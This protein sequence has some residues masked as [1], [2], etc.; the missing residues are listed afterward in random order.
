MS[1]PERK[2]VFVD[3]NF[4]HPDT[5]LRYFLQS[6]EFADAT[7]RELSPTG[8]KSAPR[9]VK[10]ARLVTMLQSGEITPET[11]L[12]A[13][14]QQPR[15]WLAVW[16]VEGVTC[17]DLN[18]P[19]QFLSTGGGDQWFGPVRTGEACWYV[20]TK[21]VRHRDLDTSVPGGRWCKIRWNLIAEVTTQY[22]ALHWNGFTHIEDVKRTTD[23][24]FEFWR[25]IPAAVA[26][27]KDELG[28]TWKR[29]DL[30]SIV[31]DK[32]MEEFLESADPEWTHLRV[33]AELKGVAVNARSAGVRE[34]NVDGLEA[35]A[36]RL[37]ERAITAS[38]RTATAATVSAA[39]KAVLKTLL[40]EWGTRSYAFRLKGKERAE[41][42]FEAHCY[43]G[44]L[45][46]VKFG[47]D[48]LQHVLCLH[49]K[50]KSRGALQFLLPYL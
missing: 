17:Q 4:T 40:Q 10:A 34:F 31:F 47:Q 49:N 37:A 3:N 42:D 24:Q 14:C 30:F 27:L 5:F 50:L 25:H 7:L 36:R 8:V 9:D 15:D 23:T 32:L 33:R 38:G 46:D 6:L 39:S 16:N 48:T 28:G 19:M 18:K 11:V 29:P 12:L 44:Q 2:H 41:L 45:T 22:V 20:F 26:N 1:D 43:F 13:L 35:L 21:Y